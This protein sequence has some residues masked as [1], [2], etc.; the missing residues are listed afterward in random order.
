MKNSVSIRNSIRYWW[1]CQPEKTTRR[2]NSLAIATYFPSIDGGSTCRAQFLCLIAAY[3]RQYFFANT[4]GFFKMRCTR[5]DEGICTKTHKIVHTP[6]AAF[7][8][9]WKTLFMQA[10]FYA[11]KK[12]PDEKSSGGNAQN[13]CSSYSRCCE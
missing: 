5:Q 3:Q 9:A 2:Q 11:G 12:K 7:P 6:A 4:T 10:A 8:Y 1:P 13:T